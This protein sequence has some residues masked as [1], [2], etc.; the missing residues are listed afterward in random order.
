MANPET[1]NRRAIPV[2]IQQYGIDN[3]KVFTFQLKKGLL[4][5]ARRTV[6]LLLLNF[7]KNSE[8]RKQ[9]LDKMFLETLKDTLEQFFF[10]L[11]ET[12]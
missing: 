6:S 11:I 5:R 12:L 1:Q 3:W 2:P 7:I 4:F 10:Y 8:I 9:N